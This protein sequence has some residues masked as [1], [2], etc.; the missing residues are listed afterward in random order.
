M[1]PT[2]KA[3]QMSMDELAQYIDYSVLKPEFI[4]M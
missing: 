3:E 2:K 1:K 4:L